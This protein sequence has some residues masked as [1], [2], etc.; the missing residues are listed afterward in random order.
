MRES[1]DPP[2][3]FVVMFFRTQSGE[4]RCRV[5]DVVSRATWIAPDTLG[6]WKLLVVRNEGQPE[7]ASNI[8]R[9]AE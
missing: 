1:T 7:P 2:G 6:L 4:L 3:G 8:D 5:T 9:P